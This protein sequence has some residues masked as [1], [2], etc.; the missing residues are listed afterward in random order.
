[1][2]HQCT[3]RKAWLVHSV[4]WLVGSCFCLF[5]ILRDNA[6]FLDLCVSLYSCLRACMG[7]GSVASSP[8]SQY[9]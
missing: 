1:M 3:L 2:N 7:C 5:F 6:Y 9:W 8:V 4:C